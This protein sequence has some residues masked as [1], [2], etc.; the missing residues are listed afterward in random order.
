MTADCGAHII[1]QEDTTLPEF[2]PHRCRRIPP[3][4]FPLLIL[5]PAGLWGCEAPPVPDPA[6][7]YVAFGDSTTD[8]PTDQDYPDF[9]RQKLGEAPETFAV[10]GSGGETSGAGLGRFREILDLGLYPNAHTLLYWQGAIAVLRFAVQVDPLLLTSPLDPAYAHTSQLASHLDAMQSEIEEVI[11]LARGAGLTVYV[12]TYFLP[13]RFPVLCEP[14]LTRV[15]LPAQA[16][17]AEGYILMLNERIRA[18]AAARGATIVDVETIGD[19]LRW[20]PANYHD[21]NHLSAQGNEQ[22]AEVWYRAMSVKAE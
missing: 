22:A 4:V 19:D 9:L 3:A 2:T 14:L 6:V 20:D 18:A 11:A 7:R 17:A 1:A 21:C 8:G 5:L 10:E 13:P 16:T 15:F 12:A